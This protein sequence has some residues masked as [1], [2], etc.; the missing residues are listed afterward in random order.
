MLMFAEQSGLTRFIIL[1]LALAMVSVPAVCGTLVERDSK[2][3]AAGIPDP[4][5]AQKAPRS[6]SRTGPVLRC[7]QYGRLILEESGVGL[8]A[9][10]KGAQSL[11]F[12]RQGSGRESVYVFD[13]NQG[14]CTLT[15][16]AFVGDSASN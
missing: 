14:M 13:L 6:S 8:P 4:P 2:L 7:W 15:G 16:A 1:G 12:P 5:V 9:A 11:A 3:A 10:A